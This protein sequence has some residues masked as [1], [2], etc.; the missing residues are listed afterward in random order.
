MTTAGMTISSSHE[1]RTGAH[2][3]GWS[4]QGIWTSGGPNFIW[5][6]YNQETCEYPFHP[7]LSQIFLYFF[8]DGL[9]E[10]HG[11]G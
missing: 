8:P 11:K 4:S 1:S 2:K 6:M 9:V 10:N 7:S 5:H 3:S